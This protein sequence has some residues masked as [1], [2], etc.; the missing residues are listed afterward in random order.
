M[1]DKQQANHGHPVLSK[2]VE[3][4]HGQPEQRLAIKRDTLSLMLLYES[5]LATVFVCWQALP[6]RVGSDLLVSV[7]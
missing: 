1:Y 3:S 6:D 4:A 7:A 2:R 5:P